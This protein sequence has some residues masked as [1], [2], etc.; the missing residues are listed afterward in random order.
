M[1]VVS[2]A[3]PLNVLV[4]IGMIGILPEL[5]STVIMPRAVAEELRHPNTPPA[6][7]EWRA[8]VPRGWFWRVRAR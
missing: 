5:F 3:S 1:I 2:D 7:R 4:R 8:T 6:V